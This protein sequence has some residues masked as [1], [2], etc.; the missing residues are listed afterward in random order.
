MRVSLN[1]VKKYVDLPDSPLFA[2]GEGLSY[3]TFTY[4]DLRIDPEAL[5]LRVTLRNTGA[6]AGSETAQVYV[7]DL[8][9]SVLTP[10]KRLIAFQK[11]A[12]EVGEARE[13]VF[14]LKR[15]D[16]SLV[17]PDERRVV[18]PGAFAL[19]VGSSS[20]DQDLLCTE[21]TLK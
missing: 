15:E 12:L 16:F 5:E 4:S 3:T 21:I 17:L 19:F 13:L 11:T 7:R 6:R 2:F 14:S 8:V 20:R 10:V 9:S 18:E 1:W